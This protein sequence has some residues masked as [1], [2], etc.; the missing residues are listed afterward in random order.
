[1]AAIIEESILKQGFEQVL[2]RIGSIILVELLSQKEKQ[3][4]PEEINIFKERITPIDQSEDMY[5]NLLYSGSGLTQRGQKD[6]TYKT[7]YFLDVYTT[8]NN[9]DGKT[10]SEDSS[11][12][13]LKYLGLIRYILSYS[14]Y[15]TLLFEEGLIGGTGVENISTLEPSLDQDSSFSRMGRITF[16]ANIL[17]GQTLWQG[18]A[19]AQSLTG[20][21]LG[22]SEKGYK[23]IYNAI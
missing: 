19:L 15:K 6:G 14:D 22:T 5:I 7:I 18:V 3:D 11:D 2:E 1:M 4:L 23:F 20:I 10:G 13:L 21:K 16:Y 17:E 12:R 9:Q 8:G